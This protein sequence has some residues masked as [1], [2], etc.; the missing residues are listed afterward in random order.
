MF[1][2]LTYMKL[3][4]INSDNIDKPGDGIIKNCFNKPSVTSRLITGV[5]NNPESKIE[6]V[7]HFSDTEAIGISKKKSFLKYLLIVGT[8]LAV[9]GGLATGGIY[10]LTGRPNTGN[11]SENMSLSDFPEIPA[12]IDSV[13]WDVGGSLLTTAGSA[14][15]SEINS[16]ATPE[17]SLSPYSHYESIYGSRSTQKRIRQQASASIT[18]KPGA[19]LEKT[20]VTPEKRVTIVEKT[21][22]TTTTPSTST[23]M[24]TKVYDPAIYENHNK[25]RATLYNSLMGNYEA[26]QPLGTL[27]HTQVSD[28]CYSELIKPAIEQA[29]A[30]DE[31]QKC[32][33]LNSMSDIIEGFI[34][35]EILLIEEHEQLKELTMQEYMEELIMKR[36]ITTLIMAAESIMGNKSFDEFYATA[37]QDYRQYSADEID[38]KNTAIWN[39]ISDNECPD[40]YEYISD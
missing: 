17:T 13:L 8:I 36:T 1:Q 32:D 29:Y 23:Y 33:S 11:R 26:P 40:S 20:N 28:L 9:G 6:R 24:A 27:F 12:S 15:S 14:L 5:A 35:D 38:N 37:M 19:V 18:E 10:Y 21:D 2:S 22:I 39:Y 34:V 7:V 30:G 25:T 31:K 3:N 4:E 16:T